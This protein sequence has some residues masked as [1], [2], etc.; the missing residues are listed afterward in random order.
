MGCRDDEKGQVGAQCEVSL[1]VRCRGALATVKHSGLCSSF[2]LLRLL[3][4]LEAPNPVELGGSSA[5]H[6]EVD[7]KQ[8][9]VL[10]DYDQRISGPDQA[11][12]CQHCRLG[13]TEFICWS[14]HI[15]QTCYDQTPFEHRGPE[16]NSFWTCWVVVERSEFGGQY[17]LD[18]V[19]NPVIGGSQ[20]SHDYS[21]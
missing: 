12:R 17:M 16:E 4:L 13:G 5:A 8:V 19:Q 18:S 21:C 2:F 3:F 6:E 15:S 20:C 14:S 7:S 11:C 9:P 1:S 10:R